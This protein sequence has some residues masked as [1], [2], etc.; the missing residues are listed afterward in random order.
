MFRK[1]LLLITAACVLALVILYVLPATEQ[2]FGSAGSEHSFTEN[3]YAGFKVGN[4]LQYGLTQNGI[5]TVAS[6]SFLIPVG[7]DYLGSTKLSTTSTSTSVLTIPARDY[8]IICVSIPSYAGSVDIGSLRFNGDSAADYT[9]RYISFAN[10]T[11]TAT[12]NSTTSA[13][14]ARL[15]GVA[16]STGR[17]GCYF[18]A[19]STTKDKGAG[20]APWSFTGNATSTPIID[21]GGWEWATTTQITSVQL[22]TAGGGNLATGSGVIVLGKSF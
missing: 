2:R 16:Q 7:F 22:L 3:F 15:F 18:I 12:D 6:T 14:L 19:N 13:T 11:T 1:I 20:A 4:S 9:S 8:L 10:G 5:L 17:S 21:T